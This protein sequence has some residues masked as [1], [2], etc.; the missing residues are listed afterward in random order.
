MTRHLISSMAATA[1]YLVENLKCKNPAVIATDAYGDGYKFL[2]K[3]HL[4]SIT[5]PDEK[6][7]FGIS[8]TTQTL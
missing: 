5:S 1:K 3:M 6:L 4:L 8:P 7:V 2:C